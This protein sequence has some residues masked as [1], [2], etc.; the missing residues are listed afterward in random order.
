MPTTKKEKVLNHLK[1]HGHITSMESFELYNATRLSGIIFNLKKE[2]YIIDTI[3]RKGKDCV[4]ADY[5]LRGKEE[6]P[7]YQNK[8]SKLQIRI[9]ELE[10]IIKQK[11]EEIKLL[12]EQVKEL[13][14]KKEELPNK[15]VSLLTQ[16]S[17]FE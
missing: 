13:K 9:E 4:Y 17:L 3:D 5:V 2:G 11:D 1:E 14:N 6:R 15:R 16:T 12:Q 7:Y 10:Q 8:K